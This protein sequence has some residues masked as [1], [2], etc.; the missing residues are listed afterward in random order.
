[1]VRLR[2]YPFL[3]LNSPSERHHASSHLAVI[4]LPVIC[5]LD[6]L[7]GPSGNLQE[8]APFGLEQ[9]SV[10]N[11][12]S[13]SKRITAARQSPSHGISAPTAFVKS[14]VHLLRVCLARYVPLS[15]F[16]NLLGISSSRNLPVLFH[17]GNALGIY[18][19]GLFPRAETELFQAS[20]PS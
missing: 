9:E 6:Q 15:G 5:A 18:P 7:R 13:G 3:D 10:R 12:P 11:R 19:S 8:Q 20:L 4:T 16:F 17:T 14:E 1:V 2:N